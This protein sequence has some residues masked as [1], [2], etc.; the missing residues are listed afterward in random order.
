[1]LVDVSTHHIVKTSVCQQLEVLP[2]YEVTSLNSIKNSS[3]YNFEDKAE[4]T[5]EV[6][7]VATAR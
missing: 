1:M 2:H 5:H 3:K 6:S 7:T 4:K